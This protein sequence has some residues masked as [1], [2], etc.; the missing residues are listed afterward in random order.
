MQVGVDIA[1]PAVQRA[2]RKVAAAYKHAQDPLSDPLQ[3]WGGLHEASDG[4]KADSGSQSFPACQLWHGDIATAAA[5][6]PGQP[7]GTA[8]ASIPVVQVAFMK[9][10]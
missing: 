6:Q 7:A 10:C 4:S 9:A 2:A 3:K 1:G 8:C 5:E